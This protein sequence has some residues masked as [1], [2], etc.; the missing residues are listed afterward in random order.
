M[1]RTVKNRQHTNL[2]TTPP[3]DVAQHTP[4]RLWQSAIP[5]PSRCGMA[6]DH[7]TRVVVT[8]G[9]LG[10]CCCCSVHSCLSRF[11]PLINLL[12][13]LSTSPSVSLP[14]L[15]L[16]LSLSV[17][18]LFL[19]F[20]LS[21]VLLTVIFRTV[22]FCVVF[23][24]GMPPGADDDNFD[25]EEAGL[26]TGLDDT[27]QCNRCPKPKPW[28]RRAE[29]GTTKD[30][31]R[32]KTCLACAQVK[33]AQVKERRAERVDLGLEP[34]RK[35]AKIEKM[36]IIWGALI[37]LF[38]KSSIA[39][40]TCEFVVNLTEHEAFADMTDPAALARAVAADIWEVTHYRW[41]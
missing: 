6:L 24:T 8:C 22:I 30:A 18:T 38:K 14:H 15:I 20:L 34:P 21:C 26:Y 11:L 39:K 19:T 2:G 31:Q 12:P 4:D 36:D 28:K 23:S 27:Y 16:R 29:F 25:D 10:G 17:R 1:G 13:P 5:P 35:R 37:D 40:D 33:A 3:P 7:V 41:M 9:C 32:S